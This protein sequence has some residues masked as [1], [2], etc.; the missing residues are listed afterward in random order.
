MWLT[1]SRVIEN[2]SYQHPSHPIECD[3][4]CHCTTAS[5]SLHNAIYRVNHGVVIPR[6]V[7]ARVV[8]AREF[9]W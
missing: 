3:N 5:T 2:G 8:T 1:A 6:V 7:T 4:L 9:S